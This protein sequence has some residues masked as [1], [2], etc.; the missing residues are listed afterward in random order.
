MISQA[1]NGA[2]FA[3]PVL[4]VRGLEKRFRGLRAVAD[5][6]FD[7]ADRK[8][9]ALIGPNGA[10]KTTV[11]NLITNLI[12]ADSGQIVFL[13]QDLAGLSPT[14]IAQRGLIRTF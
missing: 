1:K 6:S 14:S 10:G 3:D 8:I 9:T 5:V 7:V 13:K 11:F 12:H 4:S 2:E